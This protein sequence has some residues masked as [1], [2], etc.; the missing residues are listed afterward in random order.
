MDDA[1]RSRVRA[2]VTNGIRGADR[3]LIECFPNLELIASLGVGVDSL[4]LGAAQ[5]RKVVVTNTPGVIADDVADLAMGLIVDRLRRVKEAN[6]FVLAR[7]WSKGPFPLAR[8]LGGKTLG[9]VG[10]GGIGMAL[11]RRAEAFRMKVKWFGPRPKP[12]VP[13]ERVDDLEQLAHEA[14][15]LVVCC[16]GGAATH[17]LVDSRVLA[18]LGPEGVLINVAR[19]SVVDTQALV[20]AL[21]EGQI[22]G[23]ALDVV[24]GQPAVPESLLRSE[25]VLLTPHLGTATRETR[26]RMGA[27]LLESLDDHFSGRPLKHVVSARQGG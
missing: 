17:H 25:A 21:D 3:P 27:M 14:D 19:G 26:A 9:I 7:D 23:A 16:A 24:E 11:A 13:L 18:K 8:S 12:D 1:A 2:I 6:R 4:D 5:A 10:L 20:A 22:A 15:V